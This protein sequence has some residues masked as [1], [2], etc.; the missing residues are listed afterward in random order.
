MWQCLP[1]VPSNTD[2]RQRFSNVAQ[3]TDIEEYPEDVVGTSSSFYR[4]SWLDIEFI[5]LPD[6]LR[7]IASIKS[8]VKDLVKSL[9]AM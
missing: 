5:G 3:P 9:G 6:A 7:V 2:T 4:K 8:D 1:N